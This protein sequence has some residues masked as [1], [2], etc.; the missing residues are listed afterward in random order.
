MRGRVAALYTLLL[1]ANVGAWAWALVAFRAYPLLLG[2]G[3][4]AYGP[5]CATRWMPTTSP[6]STTS[7]AS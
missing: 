7:R 4:L 1:L 2:T 6:R 5:A 3:L